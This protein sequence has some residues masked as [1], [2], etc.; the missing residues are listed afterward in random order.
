MG[1]IKEKSYTLE[2]FRKKVTITIEHMPSEQRVQFLASELIREIQGCDEITEQC[3]YI[4]I[5]VHK[6]KDD[7][8]INIGCPGNEINV[9][10][11]YDQP[12]NTEETKDEE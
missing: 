2:S 5:F 7:I 10:Y 3:V 1:T 6:H 9:P 11:L 8:G 12:K 4:P